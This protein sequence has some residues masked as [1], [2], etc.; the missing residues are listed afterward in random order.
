MNLTVKEAYKFYNSYFKIRLKKRSIESK[1]SL[2]KL[3]IIPFFG[4]KKLE[5]IS[6]SDIV[7]FEEYINRKKVSLIYKKTIFM[8]LVIF[9]N[10]CVDFLDLEK[11]VASQVGFILHDENVENKIDIWN[12]K[13]FKKFIKKVD[14]KVYKYFYD[15]LYFTGCRQGEV[16]ALTFDDV[17]RGIVTIRRT[18]IKGDNGF[19]SPKTKKSIRKFK[20]DFKLR[21]EIYLLKRYYSKNFEDFNNDFFIFGGKESLAPTTIARIKNKACKKAHV[22]QIRIHDFRHSHISLLISCGV[23][24]PAICERVGHKDVKTTLNIYAHVLERD[25]IK[26]MGTLNLM[27]LRFF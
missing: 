12:Y 3:Y 21:V 13:E 25:N 1:E 8:A 23:P 20:I 16:L 2:F 22:K 6:K 9:L 5:E 15:F 7:H 4:N 24:I 19:N 27:R 14:S 10:Y 17:K 18:K 11:N 26:L